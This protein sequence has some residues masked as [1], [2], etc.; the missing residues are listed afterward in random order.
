MLI[1]V[2]VAAL[3]YRRVDI[4]LAS[5][6]LAAITD[7]LDGFV[8]RRTRVT[9]LGRFLDPTADKLLLASAFIMLPVLGAL[10]VWITVVV[11]SRDVII[12][13]GYLLIYL[14]WKSAQ[15]KVRPLGKA[16]TFLQSVCVGGVLLSLLTAA[17]AQVVLYFAYVVAL[18]TALSGLDYII[19]GFRHVTELQDSRAE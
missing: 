14:N 15:I 9:T 7:I 5:F 6:I 11:V 13:L 18:V 19:R 2:F 8:A 16:T 10:P 17:G 12:A 1:P 4:A 3:I